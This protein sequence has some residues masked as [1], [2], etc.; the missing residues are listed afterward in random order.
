MSSKL[1]PEMRDKLAAAV[2]A[3]GPKRTAEVVGLNVATIASTI[4]GMREPMPATARV[5]EAAG[6]A[7]DQ[8][9]AG[10]T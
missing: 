5:I 7:L 10:A 9:I 1:Q 8:L 6:P 4:S 2:R 3:A